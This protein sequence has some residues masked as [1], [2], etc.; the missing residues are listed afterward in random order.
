VDI[1]ILLF[2]DLVV[3]TEELQIP[4]PRMHERAFVMVPL[5]ELAPGLVHPVLGMT[6]AALAAQVVKRGG[7][8]RCKATWEGEFVPFGN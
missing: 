4:H 7:I 8:R 5:A 3:K 1:D 6:A 2:D